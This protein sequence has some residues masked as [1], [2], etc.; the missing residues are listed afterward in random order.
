[1]SSGA[2][3]RRAG[4]SWGVARGVSDGGAPVRATVSGAEWA[5]SPVGAE[6]VLVRRWTR[7]SGEDAG[8]GAPEGARSDGVL[9]TSGWGLPNNGV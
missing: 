2:G 3:V 5:G 8:V 1:M 9:V 7:A 4:V 6:P